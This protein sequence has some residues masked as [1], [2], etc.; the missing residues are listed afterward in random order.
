M[1]PVVLLTVI[2][3]LT[4][5]VQSRPF[6]YVYRMPA[7]WHEEVLALPVGAQW[8]RWYRG[9]ELFYQY[10]RTSPYVTEDPADAKLFFIP[11][12][13]GRL[14]HHLGKHPENFAH[15]KGVSDSVRK[16]L[17]WV[18]HKL[19]FWNASGH[20]RNH[21]AIFPMDQGRCDSAGLLSPE[22]LGHMMSISPGGDV[23]KTNKF[24]PAVKT[25][26]PRAPTWY[27]YHQARDI[28]LPTPLE[29]DMNHTITSPFS[30]ERA[31]TVLYRFQGKQGSWEPRHHEVPYGIRAELA[32]LH[33]LDPLPGAD[34]GVALSPDR[35]VEDMR[36]AIFCVLPPGW[37]Q[38]TVRLVRAVLSGCLPVTVYRGNDPPFAR[39]LPWLDFAVNVDP[40]EVSVLRPTLL[41]LLNNKQRIFEMQSALHA[42]QPAFSWED[43]PN[44]APA[45]LIKELELLARNM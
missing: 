33:Q 13:T 32:R 34:F 29:L 20:G 8:I 16:G 36:H 2:I 45:T 28:V 42:I 22:E 31:I 38:W 27:C 10:L 7:E 43:I 9:D 3:C 12:F 41:A 30:S 14:F 1:H 40:D 39:H 5:C 4:S 19:P 17:L 23:F 21:F 26:Q 44:N 6:I 24:M 25:L 37:G 11:F 18:Q 35:A 15:Q